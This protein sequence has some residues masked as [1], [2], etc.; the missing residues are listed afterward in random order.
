ML[1]EYNETYA[2]IMW[3]YTKLITGINSRSAEKIEKLYLE[4]LKESIKLSTNKPKFEENTKKYK[5]TNCYGYALEY[6]CPDIFMDLYEHINIDSFAFNLGFTS[7]EIYN[8]YE[9]EYNYSAMMTDF[10]NL[11]IHAFNSSID[12]KNKYGG[13]K[14][15]IY[16]SFG[17][18]HLL[19]Q[20][21]DGT[22][23][24]KL[25]YSNIIERVEP[26]EYIEG[27]YERVNVL[28][29]VKPTI[30]RR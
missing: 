8:R 25:G 26:L 13:Y 28:E 29:I 15:A 12:S 5:H 9:F 18:F 24:H 2:K 6:S 3:L 30:N 23:S 16:K 14:I 27:E 4:Y 22:W 7:D 20:N 17:D 21:M 10:E 11:D 1:K 19:R